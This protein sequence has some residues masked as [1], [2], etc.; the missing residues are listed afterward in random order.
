[1]EKII[2]EKLTAAFAPD[3]LKVINDSEKHAGHMGAGDG[4]THFRVKISSQKFHGLSPLERHR[5]IYSALETELATGLH[6]LSLSFV[7]PKP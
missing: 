5:L 6:S 3:F 1:M 2:V 4:N 7:D